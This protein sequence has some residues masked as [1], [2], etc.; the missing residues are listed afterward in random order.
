M[1]SFRQCHSGM[2]YMIYQGQA[3]RV[4]AALEALTAHE[5]HAFRKYDG[6]VKFEKGFSILKEWQLPE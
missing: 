5:N 3:L 2:V 6:K 1:L 4:L